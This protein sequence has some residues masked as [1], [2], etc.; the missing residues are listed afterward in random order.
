MRA[1]SSQASASNWSRAGPFSAVAL[2]ATSDAALDAIEG[3]AI[4]QLRAGEHLSLWI[5]DGEYSGL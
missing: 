2:L 3:T 4:D 5:W 1:A